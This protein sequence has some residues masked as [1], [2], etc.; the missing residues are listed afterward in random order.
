MKRMLL[1]LYLLCP[2][3]GFTN[4]NGQFTL[5]NA[6]KEFLSV[7]PVPYN[8][9]TY[10]QFKKQKIY[11]YYRIN[12][13]KKSIFEI[14]H[15]KFNN[16]LSKTLKKTIGRKEFDRM[17]WI[18]GIIIMII[19]GIVIYISKP[20][21]FYI[22]RRNPLNY[23]VEEEEM[24]IQ[25]L[26]H[27]TENALKEEQFSDAI[28]WQYLKTLKVLHE[29]DWISYDP[30]KTVNEYVYEIK[31]VNLRKH[32]RNLSDK[33]VYY[34]YGKGEADLERFYEFRTT[35]ETIQNMRTR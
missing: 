24:N 28:R 31:D 26:D 9:E 34:R 6:E 4:V 21:I 2:V 17:M 20:G 1:I 29:Q 23:S 22:N 7:E 5:V 19:L 16:W 11:D 8:I 25:D 35:A 13:Q 3:L 10:N 15:E 18:I 14:L 12:I 33:F 30:N 27:L 32:F